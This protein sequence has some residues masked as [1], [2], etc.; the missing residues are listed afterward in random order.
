MAP[1]FYFC[2]WHSNCSA[3]MA[4]FVQASV[5]T[6]LTSLFAEKLCSLSTSCPCRSLAQKHRVSTFP[7]SKYCI[8]ILTGMNS[9]DAHLLTI[10]KH[11]HLG[12]KPL[13]NQYS[14]MTYS[15]ICHLKLKEGPSGKRYTSLDHYHYYS[16][17]FSRQLS[18]ALLTTIIP[19]LR[20]R[21]ERYHLRQV[22]RPKRSKSMRCRP[23]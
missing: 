2:K 7:M 13:Q 3:S 17:L 12:S 18:V 9:L 1:L 8:S 22:L 20:S 23:L 10:L 15:R 19:K 5:A 21:P 6:I 4:T 16:E 11:S 14:N